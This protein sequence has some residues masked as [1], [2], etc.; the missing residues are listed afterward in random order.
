MPSV[1]EDGRVNLW[2]ALSRVGTIV[3]GQAS[4]IRSLDCF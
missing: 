4:D 2:E 3:V 1:A